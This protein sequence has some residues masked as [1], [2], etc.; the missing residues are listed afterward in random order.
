MNKQ[1]KDRHTRERRAGPKAPL[2]PQLE[3]RRQLRRDKRREL[4]ILSWRI[5]AL[6]TA[7]TILGWVLLR[8]GWTLEDSSQVVVQGDAGLRPELVARVGGLDFP[9]PLLEISPGELE[10]RLL[11]DLP[12]RSARVERRGLPA[13]LLIE[14]EGQLPVAHATRQRDNRTVK[15]MVD[16]RG[17]WI[18]PSADAPNRVPSSA[19]MIEGW[20]DDRRDVIAALL[21]QS[22][23]FGTP[24]TSIVLDPNGS[25]KLK[26]A[27]LGL[28]DLG[29][30]LSRLPEQ[31]AVI[32]ELSRS[33][34]PHLGQTGKGT[35]D[36]S[37][38]DR[39]ELELPLKPAAVAN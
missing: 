7:S 12:V 13:Q 8:H 31:I 16:A 30:D 38:P 37:N 39:P 14:L 36:L 35:L 26:T 20:T 3:R 23:G 6:L 10:S 1:T 9:Q 25:I 32:A 15:G 24:L 21:K 33:M 28:I 2:S 22:N 17:H 19:L 5:V 18:Q 4:L 11:R 29:D 27:T 34:P